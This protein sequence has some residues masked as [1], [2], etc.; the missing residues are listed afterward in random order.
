MNMPGLFF[1]FACAAFTFWIASLVDVL[2]SEF[3]GSN[4]VVWFLAV[5]FLPLLGPVL[6]LSIGVKQKVKSIA[7]VRDKSDINSMYESIKNSHFE[8]EEPKIHSPKEA[9]ET[10]KPGP[11]F[12]TKGEYERWKA[13]RMKQNEEK[14]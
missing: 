4:K 14:G 1:F 6:Y 13:E 5:T 7:P 9:I 11:P 3:T 10:K 12:K 8:T 2:K